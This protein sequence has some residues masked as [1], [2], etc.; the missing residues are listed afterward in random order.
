MTVFTAVFF[1]A[2]G[3]IETCINKYGFADLKQ[4]LDELFDKANGIILPLE[5]AN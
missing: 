1:G 2:S 4:Y 5:E 3:V